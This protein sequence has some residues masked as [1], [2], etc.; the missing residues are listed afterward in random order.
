MELL[1]PRFVLQTSALIL[2]HILLNCT[3]T[4]LPQRHR[5]RYETEWIYEF[6]KDYFGLLRDFPVFVTALPTLAI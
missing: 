2:P 5:P 3:I 1:R 4:Q 6:I